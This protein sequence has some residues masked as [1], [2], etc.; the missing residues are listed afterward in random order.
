MQGCEENP[1]LKGVLATII[2]HPGYALY[3][4]QKG[5]LNH[6]VHVN[7]E[8]GDSAGRFKGVHFIYSVDFENRTFWVQ[9][10][11][12]NGKHVWEEVPLLKR[13]QLKTIQNFKILEG[14]RKTIDLMKKGPSYK[15]PSYKVRSRAK[16]SRKAMVKRSQFDEQLSEKE[17]GVLL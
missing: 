11:R 12:R 5:E 7:C 17:G 15:G 3:M 4:I 13:A 6:M 1:S 8:A 16:D 14:A 9:N 2:A 10:T